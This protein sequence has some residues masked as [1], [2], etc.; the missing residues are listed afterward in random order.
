MW[1]TLI[2]ERQRVFHNEV[3]A[4]EVTRFAE[5]AAETEANSDTLLMSPA[6]TLR[7]FLPIFPAVLN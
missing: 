1:L 2:G 5:N 3:T 7:I 4:T 6:A